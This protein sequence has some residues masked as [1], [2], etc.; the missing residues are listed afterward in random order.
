MNTLFDCF[1][2]KTVQKK[3][4]NKRGMDSPKSCYSK[5]MI[6][7]IV[8][9]LVG[10]LIPVIFD[11]NSF[12]TKTIEIISNT[13][14][15]D[16]KQ[17]L[18]D[19]PKK[20]KSI[21]DHFQ[22]KPSTAKTGFGSESSEFDSCAAFLSQIQSLSLDDFESINGENANELTLSQISSFNNLQLGPRIQSIVRMDYFKFVKLNLHRRCTLWPDTTKCV[23]K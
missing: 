19:K 22:L 23:L 10:L 20:E 14:D 4:K 15:V 13:L 5:L 2:Q 6:V 11:L 12:K 17:R 9:L 18:E 16:L 1:S 7:S 3:T 8:T 21:A